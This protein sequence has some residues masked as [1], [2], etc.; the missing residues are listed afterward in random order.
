VFSR[1]WS[2]V[3]TS[4]DLSLSV[5]VQFTMACKNCDQEKAELRVMPRRTRRTV[6]EA[7]QPHVVGPE[8]LVACKTCRKVEPTVDEVQEMLGH[9]D[10]AIETL[11]SQLQQLE[12]SDDIM[13]QANH[14]ASVTSMVNTAFMGLCSNTHALCFK[15]QGKKFHHAAF[16]CI[17]KVLKVECHTECTSNTSNR[18][19]CQFCFTKTGKQFFH[20][21]IDCNRKKKF[22]QKVKSKN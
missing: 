4:S 9:Q 12:V 20:A 18:V 5:L 16:E 2:L 15:T 22:S 1:L 3:S 17:S 21:Q 11:L 7:V 13:S 14:L 19:Y 6:Q 10:D 8:R